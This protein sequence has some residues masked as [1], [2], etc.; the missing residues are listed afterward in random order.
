MGKLIQFCRCKSD[1]S[2]S[3]MNETKNCQIT[4]L[5]RL[6]LYRDCTH[7]LLSKATVVGIRAKC[8]LG[9]SIQRWFS[10]DLIKVLTEPQADMSYCSCP[11]KRWIRVL[12]EETTFVVWSIGLLNITKRDN[13]IG[14]KWFKWRSERKIRL[15]YRSF[16]PSS[17]FLVFFFFW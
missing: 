13:S 8:V 6:V 16:I 15:S 10:V 14:W 11:K 12:N 9:L 2:I 17:Q 7:S 4:K 3:F 1:S 5:L